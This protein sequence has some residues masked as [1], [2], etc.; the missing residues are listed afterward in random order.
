ML[1][2][3]MLDVGYRI[4]TI[5]RSAYCHIQWDL[6]AGS[7]AGAGGKPDPAALS[8]A[9]TLVH[10]A[11]IWILTDHCAWLHS[12]GFKKMIVFS[13]TSVIS[14]IHSR[15]DG[16][17]KL[18]RR[19]N[20]AEQQLLKI[21]RECSV[22]L[23]ILRPTMIYGA[24]LDSNVFHIAQ[25]IKR[26]RCAFVAGKA[27]GLRQPI[28]AHDLA[29]LC[30]K[31]ISQPSLRQKIYTVGGGETMTYRHMI[32]KIFHAL[33]LPVI[34]F[35][36]PLPL[37][38]SVLRIVALTGN[39]HYTPQMADRMNHDLCYHNGAIMKDFGF[40]PEQ[41]LLHPEEDLKSLL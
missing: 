30:M 19:I 31:I 41:F 25:F 23:I 17:R 15:N 27:G 22:E 11:P 8:G 12:I 26:F 32:E 7:K 4:I 24:G 29:D 1:C 40:T 38:R 35:S 10:C 9:D 6:S 13:S 39:L 34:I 36:L 14:K 16:E 5:S 18:A 2:Q 28:R 20:T 3:K 33:Q 21:C 37:L